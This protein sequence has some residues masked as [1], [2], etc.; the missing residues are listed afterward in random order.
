MYIC[1][2]LF[3][4]FLPIQKLDN[5]MYHREYGSRSKILCIVSYTTIHTHKEHRTNN[6]SAGQSDHAECRE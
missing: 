2:V 4:V 6:L 5:S 3:V 1:Y